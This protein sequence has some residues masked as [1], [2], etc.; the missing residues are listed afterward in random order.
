M[1][2]RL[3]LVVTV[4]ISLSSYAQQGST[5]PYSFY[6]LGT[7][8]FK[9]TVENRSMGG[10]SVYADSIHVNLRNPASYAGENL[11]VSPFNDEGRPIK[12]AVAG[13]HTNT[14]LKTSSA[15]DDASST[16]FEYLALSIPAGKLGFGFGIL[17]FTSV[18]YQLESSRT[19]NDL[20]VTD[21]RYRGEGGLNK[22]FL[23]AGYQI[24]KGLSVGVDV[25]YNF[26]NI[27][28]SSL[29]FIY[30]DEGDP[31]QYQS[32]ESNRSDLSGLSFNFGARYNTMVN[33]KLELTSA[34]TY[35]PSSDLTSK[36]VRTFETVVIN[37]FTGAENIVNQIEID[38]SED[39]LDNTTLTLP[40]RT[41]LGVGIGEPRKWFVGAEYTSLKTSDFS[42][43]LFTI[44]NATFEDASS[45]AIGGFF[46]PQY[47][48]FTK[49][50]K[51]VVYRAGVRF[52]N[53]GLRINDE[54]IKEFG[55]SFGVGLPVGRLF[56]N[57]NLGFEIGQRGT[58]S[59][60]L[61]Q[62]NFVNFQLSLSLN[63]RWFVKR[64]Y[65]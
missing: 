64:K 10:I 13:E 46:I 28:N 34:V 15:S 35:S 7:L 8:K 59:Q 2:K 60:N 6:G 14:N 58:T 22:A 16:S 3:C 20:E 19:I 57:A 50:F 25:S 43:R 41:S 48:S 61:V 56:S 42:N 37:P 26:G 1:I 36:N 55:I 52:E 49:Y 11:K 27:Q 65:N 47:T 23:G 12:F 31:I 32:R 4:L 17:P 5:S 24:T 44:E 40:A 21:N 51:R 9:G 54:S 30:D 29:E 33:N 62:E 45:I 39:G 18:G 63:D 53:T 38:L